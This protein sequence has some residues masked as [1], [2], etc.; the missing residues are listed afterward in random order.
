MGIR[1]RPVFAWD[2]GARQLRVFY[3]VT[4]RLGLVPAEVLFRHRGVEYS[5]GR[6]LS[7]LPVR[8]PDSLPDLGLDRA[9]WSGTDVDREAK[10][11][12]LTR[13]LSRLHK[14]GA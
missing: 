1:Y 10:F 4:P 7:L 11:R 9:Y 5:T 3:R 8:A 14:D 12:G 2:A 13:T 6:L